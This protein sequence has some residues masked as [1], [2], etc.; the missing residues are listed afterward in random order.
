V[1]SVEKGY[2]PHHFALVAFGGAGPLH[3]GQLAELLGTPLVLIPPHPGI[4]SALGLLS[5]DLHHDAVRTLVQRG[6]DYDV[7]GME[8]SYR[9]M[10]AETS[11][12]LTAEGIPVAQQTFARLADLRYARQGFEI[13]VAW[14]AP[15][16][17][18]AAVHQLIDAFHQRHEQLYTY[19]APDTP[20][21]IINLR[22]RALGHMD[23]L[24]LPRID[25]APAGTVPA[26]AQ[27][28]SVYF[29]GLGFVETP[30]FRRRD[31][32]AGH[33]IDGPAIVDQL[34]STMVIYPHHRAHVD[35]YGNL[36]MRLHGGQ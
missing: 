16:V 11:A 9:I 30:V 19:A 27:T 20:V 36:L 17:T 21:E 7:T 29:S 3:G 2:D 25:V 32:L 10:Q 26:A 23:K 28:R 5:T 31:L 35:A 15:T 14:P 1:V 13:T 4:L 12:H 8:A 33:A 34:D 6:P 22:L 24:T 18:E